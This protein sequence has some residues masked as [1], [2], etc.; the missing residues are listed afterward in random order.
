M[1]KNKL[2]KFV[3]TDKKEQQLLWQLAQTVFRHLLK[4]A[5]FK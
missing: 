4:V 5:G 1:K 2:Q 3:L